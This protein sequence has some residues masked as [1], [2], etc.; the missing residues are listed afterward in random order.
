MKTQ[1]TNDNT[2]KLALKFAFVYQV[3]I[4]APKSIHDSSMGH[5]AVKIYQFNTLLW[6]GS[7]HMLPLT[8]SILNVAL[9]IYF[10]ILCS[11]VKPS[12]N[13]ATFCNTTNEGGGYHPHPLR[14]F[15]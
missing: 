10:I 1:H 3:S 15:K 14:F 9:Y 12:S 2:L 7:T 5:G 6:N 8:T 13:A 11:C 4:I